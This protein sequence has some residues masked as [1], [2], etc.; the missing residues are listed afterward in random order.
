MERGEILSIAAILI[1][2]LAVGL[3][4]AAINDLRTQVEDTRAA[5]DNLAEKTS[6][7]LE[8]LDE[9]LSNLE[10]NAA[11][12]QDIEAVN[13]NIEDVRAQVNELAASLAEAATAEDLN[14]LASRLEELAEKVNGLEEKLLFPA[15]IVDGTG[16]EVVIPSRPER[17]VSLAPSTTEALYFVGALDRIVGVDSFS[18]YPPEI[19]NM[20]ESGEVAV[21]GGFADPSIEEIL[22]LNPDLVV[23]VAGW[24]PH[25]KVK[26]ILESMGI[27]VV[28]LPQESINDVRRGILILGIATGNIDQAVTALREFDAKIYLAKY[29]SETVTPV[30]TALIVWVNPIWVAGGGT[31]QNDIIEYA[32]GVNVFANITGWA[33][34][35]PEDLLAADPEVIILTH[36]MNATEFTSYLEDA[37]GDAAYN[38]TAVREGRI[39]TIQGDYDNLL[40][41]PSPRVADG[42]ALLLYIL[43]P[44]LYNASAP[45]SIVSPETVPEIPLP[46]LP[47][48]G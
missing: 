27:P 4:Y 26:L 14:R 34:V 2:L 33:S 1:T 46:P 6:T 48:Q 19:K 10:E 20:T 12:R 23:G 9:R 18:D 43:H 35:S 5:V 42:V 32:G 45:P 38:I 24:G 39:Y 37:L 17:I 40:S 28:L 44:D 31:F 8:S 29:Y 47:V 3:L 25:E 36:D 30:R 22:A 21:I 41:R 16:S 7:T 11:T 15:T 13:A